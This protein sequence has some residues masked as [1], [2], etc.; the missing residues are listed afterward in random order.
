MI[1]QIR[2]SKI[3]IDLPRPENEPWVHLTVQKVLRDDNYE[4]VNLLTRFDSIS[5]PI[6]VLYPKEYGIPTSSDTMMYGGEILKGLTAI[7]LTLLIEKYGGEV[8]E[9]GDLIL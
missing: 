7:V 3:V 5:L 2:V 1:E 4:V 6:S 8:N 9:K